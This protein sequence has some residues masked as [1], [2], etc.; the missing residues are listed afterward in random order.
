MNFCDK[1]S[2]CAVAYLNRNNRTCYKLPAS[3]GEKTFKNT[4]LYAKKNNFQPP[5]PPKP[6]PP[7]PP[8]PTPPPPPPPPKIIKDK[9]K[10][11]YGAKDGDE[12]YSC[13][14]C[15]DVVDAH[16]LKRIPFSASKFVQCTPIKY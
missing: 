9:S 3:K 13:V 6:S 4:D 1:D 15:S 14:T 12:D 2:A 11:C 16:T 5:P 10:W 8:P 7:T